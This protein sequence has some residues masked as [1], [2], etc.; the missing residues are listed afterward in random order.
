MPILHWLDRDKDIKAAEHIPYRLLEV[1]PELSYGDP[2]AEN[3]LI[4]GMSDS[5]WT[6]FR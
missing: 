4:Q 1:V 5:T 3:M 6:M 2:T